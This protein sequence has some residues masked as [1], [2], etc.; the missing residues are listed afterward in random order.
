[1]SV[2]RR[3]NGAG[4]ALFAKNWNHLR[5]GARPLSRNSQQSSALR[6]VVTLSQNE[7]NL[8]TTANV[9]ARNFKDLARWLTVQ[10]G[11]ISVNVTTPSRIERLQHSLSL[12]RLQHSLS[13]VRPS[14]RLACNRLREYPKPASSTRAALNDRSRRLEKCNEHS[15][16]ADVSGGRSY[17]GADRSSIFAGS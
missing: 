6:G 13:L 14:L 8:P 7:R 1:M 3:C 2:L 17:S 16:S 10:I 5:I 9:D 11:P 4:L 12:E 15:A